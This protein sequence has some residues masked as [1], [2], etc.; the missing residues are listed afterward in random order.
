[1][2]VSVLSSSVIL[3]RSQLLGETAGWKRITDCMV[4]E[5]REIKRGI[6]GNIIQH[7]DFIYGQRSVE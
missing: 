6:A 7:T 2:T 5:S 4:M 1:V 3:G